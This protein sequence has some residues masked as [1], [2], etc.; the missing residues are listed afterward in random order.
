VINSSIDYL[1]GTVVNLD[2]RLGF[3]LRTYSVTLGTSLVYGGGGMYTGI[4]A[5]G[6]TQNVDAYCVPMACFVATDANNVGVASMPNG[7]NLV[8]VNGFI[9]GGTYRVCMLIIPIK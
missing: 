9:S 2:S 1:Y 7:H 8:R 6:F 3:E 4:V 5:V